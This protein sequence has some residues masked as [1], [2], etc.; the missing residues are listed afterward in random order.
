MFMKKQISSLFL[1]LF[2]LSLVQTAQASRYSDVPQGSL[3]YDRIE[4]L[5]ETGLLQGYADG[6]FRPDAKVNR[7]EMLAMLYRATGKNPDAGSRNCFADVVAGSWYESFVCDAAAHHYVAGYSDGTFKPANTVNRVE[8]LKMITEVFGIPVAEVGEEARQVVKFVDVSISGWYTRYLY[9]AYVKGILPIPGQ[10]TS[11]FY[12]DWP[13]LRGEAAAMIF[14]A[15]HVDLQERRQGSSSLSSSAASQSSGAAASGNSSASSTG[16]ESA[17]VPF[18]FDVSGKFSA[19][20]SFSYQFS[21]DSAATVSAVATLQAG[22]PGS[23]SCRLYLLTSEGF[24]YEYYLGFAEG[25]KCSLKAA[26]GPGAYQLQLQPTQADTTFTVRAQTVT[27]DGN[28]GMREA[29]ALLRSVARTGTL[30]PGDLQ[31]WFRFTVNAATGM[32][33]SASD[34]TQLTCMIYAMEDVNLADFNG[35]QCN[36]HYQYLPGTYYVAIGRKFPSDSKQTYTVVL[37]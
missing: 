11:R 8:S 18:P 31:D 17:D 33:V 20:K 36:E 23:L 26:V 37:Q 28:D 15:I 34:S 9:A 12:P 14:N 21:L 22:Q 29:Q 10:E 6:T 4:S 16:A 2:V 3:F 24:S 35:P 19:R 7:A 32:E 13:L 1:F 25:N 30:V 5:S 27:G